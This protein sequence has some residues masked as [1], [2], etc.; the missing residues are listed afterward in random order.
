LLF[1]TDSDAPD[2]SR[3]CYVGT[4]NVAAGR[5]AADFIKQAL[6]DGGKIM[7]FVGW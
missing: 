7:V 3:V 2:T 1:T 6:P 4:D 5:Q